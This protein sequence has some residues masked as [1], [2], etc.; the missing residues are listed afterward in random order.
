MACNFDY[1]FNWDV[2]GGYD[3]HRGWYSKRITQV[4][5]PA[6]KILLFENGDTPSLNSSPVAYGP[7]TGFPEPA[8]LLIATRHHNRSNVFYADGHAGLF[9][10]LTLKDDTITR[11]GDSVVYVKYFYLTSE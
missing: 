10:S 3:P 5:A 1:V 11:D 4:R 9:D 2:G 7:Y 6:R 8:H